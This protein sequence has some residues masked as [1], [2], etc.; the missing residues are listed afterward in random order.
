M[1]NDSIVGILEILETCG[2]KKWIC[3]NAAR[4]IC[5][6]F[7]IPCMKVHNV[8]WWHWNRPC[9]KWGTRY[10]QL[11]N[12]QTRH[13]AYVGGA[14][15]ASTGKCKYGK[16]K[17]KVAKCVRVE[18]TSTENSSSTATQRWKTQVWKIKVKVSSVSRVGNC[19]Y[20]KIE[21]GITVQLLEIRLK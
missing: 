8:G 9:R 3:R 16:L 11:R 19:K 15:I 20:G 2:R 13:N 21:Y 7:S 18:N 12:K 6:S 14:E 10:S 4:C 17:Y 1:V 5:R